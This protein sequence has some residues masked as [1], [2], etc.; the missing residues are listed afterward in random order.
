MDFY[1]IKLGRYHRAYELSVDLWFCEF[2]AIE[3]GRERF[4]FGAA[5]CKAIIKE[6]SSIDWDGT[7]SRKSVDR[8]TDLFYDVIWSCFGSLIP[9]TL[10]HCA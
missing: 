7:F 1:L 5:D 4:N 10:P 2:K 6:L 3:T 8:C 9:N